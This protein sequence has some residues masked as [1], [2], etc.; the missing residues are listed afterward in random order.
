MGGIWHG[1]RNNWR[2]IY[3]L[4]FTRPGH[5]S[6]IFLPYILVHG[7]PLCSSFNNSITYLCAIRREKDAVLRLNVSLSES[8]IRDRRSVELYW[9]VQRK[10]FIYE[11]ESECF[12]GRSSDC[13]KAYRSVYNLFLCTPLCQIQ[14]TFSNGKIKRLC[15]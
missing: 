15:F 14:N 7:K 3:F 12:D 8:E 6:L 13:Y 4:V 2:D 9:I 10:Y 1:V 11:G 5:I